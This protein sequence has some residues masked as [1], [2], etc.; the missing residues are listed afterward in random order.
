MRPGSASKK[1]LE[2]VVITLAFALVGCLLS[3]GDKW[4]EEERL[5]KKLDK[6][7]ETRLLRKRLRKILMQ[8]AAD[9]DLL[10]TVEVFK[11]KYYPGDRVIM[12][13]K[14]IPKRERL[15]MKKAAENEALALENPITSAGSFEGG[16]SPLAAADDLNNTGVVPLSASQTATNL[17]TG[18]GEVAG[19]FD[20]SVVV[21][22]GAPSAT[23]TDEQ[24]TTS[25]KPASL[26][27]TAVSD[28]PSPE[29]LTSPISSNGGTPWSPGQPMSP[30]TSGDPSSSS[31]RMLSE[32]DEELKRLEILKRNAAKYERGRRGT[33]FTFTTEAGFFNIDID[34]ASTERVKKEGDQDG[35]E[36]PDSADE[37]YTDIEEES[38]TE[39]EDDD[40]IDVE[41]TGEELLEMEKNKHKK[42]SALA[43][44]NPFKK[45]LE[46]EK[47]EFPL[48][49]K[50]PKLTPLEQVCTL[51][52]AYFVIFVCSHVAVFVSIMNAFAL[53]RNKRDFR[54]KRIESELDLQG[55]KAENSRVN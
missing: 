39:P 12:L 20:S 44:K 43:V 6:I 26:S 4:M 31:P 1:L 13:G 53:H 19:S 37:H 3:Q 47:P 50:L 5:Q 54:T 18:D 55:S 14:K 25:V 23:V 38:D 51:L 52:H 22:G 29:V 48:R 30:Y 28:D 16:A 15:R 32:V 9:E 10:E 2:A 41:A 36:I 11:E 35:D 21:E 17:N 27:P 45:S 24:T 40:M 49:I 42:K 7:L 33:V 46:E 8:T 34:K